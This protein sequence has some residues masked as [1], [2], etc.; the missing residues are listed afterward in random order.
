MKYANVLLEK[1]YF[2]QR[3]VFRVRNATVDI[4]TRSIVVEW[5]EGTRKFRSTGVRTG[6]G[7]FLLQAGDGAGNSTLHRFQN[8]SILEGFWTTNSKS[9]FW[10][11]HLPDNTVANVVTIPKV[12]M[13][14]A[15]KRP[16]P[17]RRPRVAA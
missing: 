15:T 4:G 11:L 2:D 8:S 16:K 13:A 7:H 9:G 1:A 14:T 6:Q 12:L 5:Q 3:P 17:A 10:R